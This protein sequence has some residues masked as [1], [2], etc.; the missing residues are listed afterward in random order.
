M[1]LGKGRRERKGE[2]VGETRF[3]ERRN[4]QKAR[5]QVFLPV[6]SENFAEACGQEKRDLGHGGSV[7]LCL[8]YLH[9]F[10]IADIHIKMRMRFMYF[11]VNAAGPFSF[12]T[13]CVCLIHI[14][15]VS[16]HASSSS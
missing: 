9:L 12:F 3:D 4:Q 16:C 5:S 8:F 11:G 2:G 13:S 1:R 7:M 10:E 14:S 6:S 15:A